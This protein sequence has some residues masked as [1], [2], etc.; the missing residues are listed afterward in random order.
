MQG[1]ALNVLTLFL[2]TRFPE[3][4]PIELVFH[5]ILGQQIQSF[6]YQAAGPHADLALHQANIVLLDRDYAL[7]LRCF[8]HCGY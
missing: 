8:V 4:N 7:I 3:L 2:P 6:K 1:H 5:H